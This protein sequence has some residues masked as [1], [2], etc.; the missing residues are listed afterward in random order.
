MA[1][2]KE[3]QMPMQGGMMSD[4]EMQRMMKQMDS[5]T[6]TQMHGMTIEQAERMAKQQHGGMMSENGSKKKSK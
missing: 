1:A 2:K 5:N 4:E 6:E 3:Q